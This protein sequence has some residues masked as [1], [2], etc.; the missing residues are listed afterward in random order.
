[1]ADIFVTT[2]KKEMVSLLKAGLI[3]RGFELTAPQYTIFQARKPGVTC[4]LYE[5]L[6][7]TVQGKNKQELLEFFI[8]PEILKSPEYTYRKEL[9][10]ETLDKRARIGVDEAGKGDY[11]GPLCVAGVM[12]DEPGLHKLLEIGVRD[13]KTLS[14]DQIRKMAQKIRAALP[15][16]ILVLRPKKY[17]EL[18]A[19]FHNLNALLGWGHA[20]V[21]E[22]LAEQ[23][24]AS[25]AIIDK[26]AGEHVVENA[27]KKKGLKI[28]L[29]QRVRGEAD[30]VVAAASIL[31]R[32]AFVEFLEETGKKF[33]VNLPKGAAAHV[34][35]AARRFVREQGRE[36]LGEVAKL[37]FKTTGQLGL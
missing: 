31:A 37:H 25:H 21:I 2:I 14:D 29:E 26:F 10:L 32:W 1:M 24:G 22:R 28:A 19:S 8:E 17:N 15:Y 5:S 34:V 23:T 7:L 11:F 12:A 18:Y 3:E 30:V 36:A 9:A 6:K 20:T 16:H 27:L 33:G 35:E 13:S 4:T